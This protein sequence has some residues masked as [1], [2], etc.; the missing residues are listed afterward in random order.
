MTG[1]IRMAENPRHRIPAALLAA[2]AAVSLAG[3]VHAKDPA[4]VATG[5]GSA[6][7]TRPTACP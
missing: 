4:P 1:R 5:E 2:L 3:A 7:V 6:V